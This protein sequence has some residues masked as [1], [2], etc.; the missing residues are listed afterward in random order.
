MIGRTALH[1]A[2]GVVVHI[3]RGEAGSRAEIGATAA[4]ATAHAGP[5]RRAAALRALPLPHLSTGV[6]VLL[7]C[8]TP[9]NACAQ[10][11]E[12]QKRAVIRAVAC[13]AMKLDVGLF[14]CRLVQILR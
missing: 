8:W 10:S 6:V 9:V 14:A 7:T 5:R 2:A 12:G 1:A 4:A 11:V 3:S 13:A